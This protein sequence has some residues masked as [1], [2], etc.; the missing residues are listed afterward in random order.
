MYR[1][2]AQQA[3]QVIRVHDPVAAGRRT[4]LRAAAIQALVAVVLALGL[5]AQG[6]RAAL[7]AGIGGLALALG[8]ALAAWM[9]LG[10]I[11]PARVAFGRLL[12]GAMAKWGI[13]LVA[14][15]AALAVWRLPPLPLLAGMAV[16]LLAYLLALNAPSWGVIERRNRNRKG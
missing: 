14:L 8:N 12:L 11:V 10:G 2:A 4:A 5:L 16:G 7:A 3:E 6:P 9:A 15:T 1:Q 13:A